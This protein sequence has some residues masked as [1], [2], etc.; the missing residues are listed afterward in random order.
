MKAKPTG[1]GSFSS[2]KS[3]RGERVHPILTPEN[4]CNPALLSV[5][6]ADNCCVKPCLCD[7]CPMCEFN[8]E[9]DEDAEI[10]SR[11]C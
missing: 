1:S 11:N 8:D 4:S 9:D 10:R 7:D 6:C 3:G 2:T 5:P